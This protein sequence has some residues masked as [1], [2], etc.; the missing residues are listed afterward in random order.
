[1]LGCFGI[2]VSNSQLKRNNFVELPFL[3]TSSQ[4]LR[5]RVATYSYETAYVELFLSSRFEPT[6]GN[7]W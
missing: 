6:R 3:D 7:D 4:E 5:P 2:Y 1:M